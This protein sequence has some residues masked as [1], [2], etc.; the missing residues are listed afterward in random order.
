MATEADRALMIA[1]GIAGAVFVYGGMSGRSPLLAL[2]TLIKG[3]KP[4]VTRINSGSQSG[5]RN[6]VSYQR[7]SPVPVSAWD[8]YESTGWY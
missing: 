1:F 3:D 8:S 7:F 4:P 5:Y 2:H 6:P